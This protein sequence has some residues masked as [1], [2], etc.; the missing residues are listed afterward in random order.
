MAAQKKKFFD[1]SIPLINSTSELLAYEISSLNNKKIKIDLTRQLRGKSIEVNF[2]VKVKD[3][4][5]IAEPIELTLLP[6]FIRRMFRK[7]ISYI[8]DSFII[9]CKDSFLRVKPFLITRKRVSRSIRNALRNET[10]N[11]LIDY[12]KDKKGTEIFSDIVGNRLQKGLSL[13]LKKIYPLALCEIRMLNIEKLK[14]QEELKITV[15]KVE[16]ET[17]TNNI[18]EKKEPEKKEKKPRKTKKT[19]EKNPEKKEEK[20]E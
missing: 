11:W 16:K 14:E 10:K 8:E 6:F 15:E 12:S 7:S 3:G 1:V 5:A 2:K 18:E 17:P 4:K 20:Q 13:K 19:E 9:E